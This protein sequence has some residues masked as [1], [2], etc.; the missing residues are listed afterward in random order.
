MKYKRRF[1]FFLFLLFIF[2]AALYAQ[3]EQ[4]IADEEIL[5]KDKIALEDE[6]PVEIKDEGPKVP[7]KEQQRIELELKT[8]TLPEL[9]AWCRSLGLSEGGTRAE[10]T[11]RIREHFRM[12]EQ[13][14]ADAENQKIITIESAQTTEYFSIDVIDED[15]ARLKGDVRII[16]RD[17]ED[18]HKIKADEII[19]NRTR[20]ILTAIGN[21][22]YTKA[23][24]DTTEIFRGKNITVNIDNWASIFLDGNS[25]KMLESEEGTAYR[26]KGA[27]ISI[28]EDDVMILRKAEISNAYNGEA[29][30]SITASRL[31]LLPGSDFAIF[32]AWLKVGEIPVLYIPFF[33]FPADDVIFHPVFGYRTREGGFI[34]TTFYILGRPKADTTEKSSITR[35]MGNSSDMERERQGMFLRSTGKKVKDPNEISLKILADYYTNLGAYLAVDFSMPKKGILNPLDFSIGFG[36][37]RTLTKGANDV[38]DPYAPN[39]DGTFETDYSNF[40]SMTVPFRY[41]IKTSSSISGKYGTLSWNFPYYSDPF[42][43]KDFL[44]RAE[45]M[46]WMNMLQQGAAMEEDNIMTENNINSYQWQMSGNFNPQLKALAPYVNNISLT[47]ISTTLAFNAI[48]DNTITN[49]ENPAR[50]FFA[51]DKYTIYNASVSISG[52]PLTIGEQSQAGGADSKTKEEETNDPFKGIGTPRSPWTNEEENEKAK[53]SNDD[54]LIPPVLSQRFDLPKAGNLKFSIDYQLSP[55]SSSELQFM[56]GYNHWQ[57]NDQVDWSE[58]QSVLMGVGGNGSVNFRMDHSAGLFSNTVTFSGSGTWREYTYL[59]EEAEAYRTPQTSEGEKDEKKIE[60]AKK[61]Q[62]RQTNYTTSYAYNGTVRPLYDNPIFGQSSLQYSF[63]GTLVKSKKYEDGNGPE[64]TPQWGVWAKEETKDGKEIYGLNSHRITGNIAAN[65]MDYQ[66]NISI[67]ADLP[68]FD[69][70]ISTNATF[71]AWISETNARIEFKKPEL[72]NNV[73]NSEWIKDPF[74]LTETLKFGKVGSFS[75]YMVVSPEEDNEI[76]TITS[77]LTLWS[78]R[79]SFSA[80]KSLK[81]E[82]IYTDPD[83]TTKGGAWQQT[84]DEPALYPR[85]LLFTYNPTFPNIDIIKNKLKISLNLN[86]RLFFDLQRHTNS[87]FQ[88]T[89]GFTLNIVDFLDLTL[90]ATSENAVIFRY[91]KDV[92]GMEDLTAM[93][94]EG[95]QNNFFIDLFDS[96]NFGD[97]SKRQR[98][99][100]KM[101]SLNLTAVHH[102]GDWTAELGLSVA[103]YLNNNVNPA[104]YELNTELSFLVQWSAITEIKTD[105]GYEKRTEKW[106]KK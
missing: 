35:I 93:Y 4:E 43:D 24:G 86:T 104:K 33:F 1:F 2:T 102:L 99:G 55:T 8:S 72:I 85:E 103:P 42:V 37:S 75:Y 96:F 50:L 21:V 53:T 6:T 48:P 87:N 60:E 41:K 44:T 63:K 38:Y 45:A 65:I 40:F 17:K 89:M 16:L 54:K 64:L 90:S 31:W 39:Y 76:T 84:A 3:E 5:N 80:T 73:P 77:S 13:E 22:E 61:Q 100:F 27:V 88:F 11:S 10:L 30:W 32:N 98:S 79:A 52:T 106:I 66:Q 71:R 69:P 82:F 46:D 92:P 101:K 49:L 81:Y 56:S 12:S 59:N 51:P 23:K 94:I 74:H 91:F 25:D 78:F 7:D 15:Y 36:L 97:E 67:S 47:N 57:K 95:D 9:A 18:E 58:V 83:D 105:L 34:Q 62:Y 68:P 20:N 26:F 28:T 19:F 70:L 14:K 29:L